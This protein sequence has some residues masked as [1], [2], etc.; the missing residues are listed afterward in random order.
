MLRDFYVTLQNLHQVGIHQSEYICHLQRENDGNI[1]R[2]N[3]SKF[4]LLYVLGSLC[5]LK[6]D[7]VFF[8]PKWYAIVTVLLI[9]KYK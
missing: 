3:L 5:K 8:F 9:A 6:L 1:F 2:L 7:T 4:F